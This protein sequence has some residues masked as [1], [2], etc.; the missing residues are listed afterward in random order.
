MIQKLER[1]PSSGH[2]YGFVLQG[3][4]LGV[5]NPLTWHVYANRASEVGSNASNP[6]F[7]LYR[8]SCPLELVH[9]R[10]KPLDILLNRGDRVPS[11]LVE[12]VPL[13]LAPMIPGSE[14]VVVMGVPPPPFSTSITA[15]NRGLRSPRVG[16][17]G[18]SFLS[19]A[20]ERREDCEDVVDI[21]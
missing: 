4:R 16:S 20:N 3:S 9:V 1:S 17:T 7:R 11:P 10:G 2:G 5:E 15:L 6:T 21:C 13:P 12:G 18:R 19:T 14:I 8:P